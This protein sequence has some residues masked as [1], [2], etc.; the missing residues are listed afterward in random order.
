MKNIQKG[1]SINELDTLKL[2]LEKIDKK[3][4]LINYYDI[5]KLIKR[6]FFIIS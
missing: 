2:Q 5:K 4:I 3:K 1:G 6:Q